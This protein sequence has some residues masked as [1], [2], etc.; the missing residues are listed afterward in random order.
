MHPDTKTF[1]I[2]SPGF[3]ADEA[4]TTC[5]PAQQ[6]F[7]QN[8][9][10]VFPLLNIIVLSFQ[11]PFIRSAYSWK[12]VQVISFNGRNK[13][14]LG[15]VHLWYK[16]RKKLASLHRTQSISG[17]FSFWCTECALVGDHFAKKH[18]LAHFTWILGQDA[19]K[20]NK[21]VRFIQPQPFSLVAMSDFLADEFEK[22]HGIRPQHV[23]PNGIDERWFARSSE[24]RA[25]DVLG[26]GS[27]I[28]LKQYAIFIDVIAEAKRKFSR[29]KAVICGKGPEESSL[30]SQ[31]QSLKLES[32]VSFAGEQQHPEVLKKMQRTK[33][34]LHPSNYEGF[35]TVCLEALYA[36]AHVI[37]FCKPM[38]K[39][40]AHWH[41]VKNKEEMIEKLIEL[42]SQSLDHRGVMPY[43]MKD[44][45]T[46]VMELFGVG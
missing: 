23:I 21:F 14:G 40:I 33:V 24:E 13:G 32:N 43:A 46:G 8:L 30:Q 15:R 36:G 44:V 20:D 29:I 28:P 45:V 2:L 35:S 3:P 6:Q 31:L 25:I 10:E 17:I 22:N 9:Q 19:K 4:D 26:A 27:L 12:N 38:K 39:D 42:L 5:L 37:S 16:V 41:I 11:Y 18:K 34:F 7:V 1:I